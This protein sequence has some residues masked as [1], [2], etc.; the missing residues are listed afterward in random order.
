MNETADHAVDGRS[1]SGFNYGANVSSDEHGGRFASSTHLEASSV[2]TNANNATIEESFG[3]DYGASRSFLSSSD[4]LGRC[5][6]TEGSGPAAE[7]H[8]E[9]S[10]YGGGSLETGSS[11][12]AAPLRKGKWTAEEVAYTTA[13]IADFSSGCMLTYPCFP[14]FVSFDSSI[15]FWIFGLSQMSFPLRASPSFE[16]HEQFLVFLVQ[17]QSLSVQGYLLS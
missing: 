10:S 14:I 15:Y 1:H 2:E 11:A 7:E 9:A 13:I 5:Q 17:V 4:D 8:A 6:A 16:G 12:P 3:A